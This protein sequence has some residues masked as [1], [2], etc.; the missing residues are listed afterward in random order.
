MIGAPRRPLAPAELRRGLEEARRRVRYR[1]EAARP[2]PDRSAWKR[3]R[4][5]DKA[6][7][8]TARSREPMCLVCRRGPEPVKQRKACTGCGRVVFTFTHVEGPR[9]RTCRREAQESA[10]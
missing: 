4:G 5:C 1:A 6:M 3:C 8:T 7:S 10:R 2:R 9:C